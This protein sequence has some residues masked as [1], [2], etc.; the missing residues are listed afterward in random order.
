M[1]TKLIEYLKD[2]LSKNDLDGL[3]IN[4]TNEFLVEY[5]MLELNSRYYVTGFTGSTGD[6]LFTN[7]KIYLFVDTRYHEQADNQV[8]K[9][10]IEVVKMPM[11]QSFLTAL[12]QIVPSY[13]KLGL[14]SKKIT[15]NFYDC[16]YKNLSTKNSTIKLINTDPVIEF[17]KD[18]IKNINYNIFNVDKSITGKTPDEKY[19]LIKEYAGEKFNILVTSLEDI[20]YLTNKRSYNFAYS[21]VF[22]AKAIINENFATIYT[23]CKLSDIGQYYKV[24][25]MDEF[26][27]AVKSIEK[28]ELYIDESQLSI[29]DYKLIKDN[30]KILKSHL[31]LFKTVKSEEEIEH[32]KK[33]FERSDNALKIIYE[34]INSETIYTEYDYYEALVNSMKENGAESLSFKPI[35]AAGSNTSIIHYSSPSKE[36][37]VEDGDF[38]LIDY[39]GYYEGGLA[40]DTTR[41]FIKG[42]PSSEQKTAYTS[43]L[44]AFLN[45]YY[46][47]YEKKSSYFN[48]D[49]IARDNIYKTAPEGCEF[50]HSTGHGVG[51][52]VHENP[53]RVS[54]S[55]V[56]KTKII[57]NTVFSIEPGLYKEGWGGI[58]LEN[59]VYAK[60]E[61]DKIVMKSLSHFPFEIKL[62]DLSLMSDYEKYYYMKWQANSCIL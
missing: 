35:V 58:R 60:K 17:K 19:S 44:K 6:V 15:K 29:F 53:P 30:N 62:V 22:P 50:S 27:S 61:E 16:L 3:V 49:K 51:I 45:A 47:K 24:A 54:S 5:N 7:D 1:D 4:S 20:A 10:Y 34:M 36:K 52:S 25:A 56:S 55:D 43:V 38:L 59:T 40:T 14:I 32:L 37:K 42:T 13:F 11:T 8:D 12:T 39:G 41:T 9:N 28:S 21:S 18:E 57:E 31:K 48:I 46:T 23:D 33:C 26:E 2:Y